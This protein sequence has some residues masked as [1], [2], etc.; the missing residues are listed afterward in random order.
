MNIKIPTTTD[1]EYKF[2]ISA[3]FSFLTPDVMGP[4]TSPDGHVFNIT[5]TDNN[6]KQTKASLKIFA[7]AV[8]SDVPEVT[9]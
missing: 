7:E 9:E 3:F 5:V 6:D 8:S 1:T 2:P 4:T